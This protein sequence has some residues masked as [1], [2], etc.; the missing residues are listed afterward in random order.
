VDVQFIG[1][2]TEKIKA[3]LLKYLV[4]SH[5]KYWSF[6][7]SSDGEVRVR[8]ATLLMW[9]FRVRLFFMSR[10]LKRVS[11]QTSQASLYGFIRISTLY[12]FYYKPLGIAFSEFYR[13]F[14]N[15]GSLEKDGLLFCLS[16][17]F[18]NMYS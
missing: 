8:L 6:S 9:Y 10:L 14:Y 15:C 5:H 18:R 2:D 7:I 12:R 1:R 16:R 11:L 13:C 4:K 3:Y 17:A